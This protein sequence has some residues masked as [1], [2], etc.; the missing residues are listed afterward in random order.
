ALEVVLELLGLAVGD[1]DDPV[2]VLEHR[3]AGLVV[4]DLPGNGEELEA[5][6]EAG[7]RAELDRNEVEEQRAVRLGRET[8]EL[9]DVGRV[10]RLVDALEIGGLA[11]Q[12]GAVEDDLRDDFALDGV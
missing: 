7:D 8:G 12:S 5:G 6:V 1:E 9:A 4:E 3:A 10:H 2:R 11:G